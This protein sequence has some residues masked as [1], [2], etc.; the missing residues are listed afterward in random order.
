MDGLPW[1]PEFGIIFASQ[2]QKLHKQA[3]LLIAFNFP[4][5]QCPFL[6]KRLIEVGSARR[7]ICTWVVP[8]FHSET[9][10]THSPTPRC[11]NSVFQEKLLLI[12]KACSLIEFVFVHLIFLLTKLGWVGF[13]RKKKKKNPKHRPEK[14]RWSPGERAEER[15]L[16]RAL[17]NESRVCRST[18][19]CCTSL[20]SRH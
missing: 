13:T 16:K 19:L 4:L 17:K 1:N 11:L 6:N 7:I 10:C 18:C 12:T 15:D 20:G 3:C 5:K 2:A 9:C 8:P 14:Y